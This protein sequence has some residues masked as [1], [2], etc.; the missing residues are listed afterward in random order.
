MVNG[1]YSR[2]T[3]T[4][5]SPSLNIA[6][7]PHET[8]TSRCTY[9][10]PTSGSYTQMITLP[11]AFDLSPTNSTYAYN[12]TLGLSVPFLGTGNKAHRDMMV[13]LAAAAVV[14]LYLLK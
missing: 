2:A 11:T 13:T 14:G 4:F 12:G 8:C 1:G 9:H 3:L 6:G 7:M 10:P 5:I